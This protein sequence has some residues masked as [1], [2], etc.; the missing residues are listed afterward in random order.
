[1]SSL[2]GDIEGAVGGIASVFTG[3]AVGGGGGG[4]F[5]GE[6]MSLFEGA[7]QGGASGSGGDSTLGDIAK[8]AGDVAPLLALL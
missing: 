6:L 7:S 1:M 3:G 5:L 4:G 2:L 8:I